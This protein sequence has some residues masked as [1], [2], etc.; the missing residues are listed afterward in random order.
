MD[1]KTERPDLPIIVADLGGGGICL[2]LLCRQIS[3][4]SS[5]KRKYFFLHNW[6]PINY[7][8]PKDFQLYEK[9]KGFSE[10]E[11]HFLLMET[12]FPIIFFFRRDMTESGIFLYPTRLDLALS[13]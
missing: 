6:L 8:N 10:E 13:C 2:Q 4:S 7:Q 3:G 9:F 11:H 12:I 5:N 1:H